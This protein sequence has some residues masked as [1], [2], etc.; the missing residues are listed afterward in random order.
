MWA[1]GRG[2]RPALTGRR[3]GRRGGPGRP[4]VLPPGRGQGLPQTPPGESAPAFPLRRGGAARGRRGRAPAGG[5]PHGDRGP[6]LA[7]A[8]PRQEGEG[9]GRLRLPR[10][11]AALRAAAPT[12]TRSAAR[13]AAPRGFPAS[14]AEG[15]AWRGARRGVGSLPG[16]A[17]RAGPPGGR[18]RRPPGRLP[19]PGRGKAP[20][21]PRPAPEGRGR[22]DRTPPLRAPG[23]PEGRKGGKMKVKLKMFPRRL[24]PRGRRGQAARGRGLPGGPPREARRGRNRRAGGNGR[25]PPEFG[26]PG[27]AQQAA[28]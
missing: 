8:G 27:A 15:G 3:P 10:V 26:P 13:E 21:P 6:G 11:R 22:D 14:G 5:A 7:R 9:E 16:S 19:P 17:R 25:I 4:L 20:V 12:R 1:S 18:G 23:S 28:P 24:G 2:G